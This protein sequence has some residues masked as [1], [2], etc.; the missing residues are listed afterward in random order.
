MYIDRLIL[1]FVAGA[2]LLS[3]VIIDWWSD[4]GSAWYRPYMVWGVL[5][6][7]AFWVTRSR[8]LNDL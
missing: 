5:I 7:L 8:D 4:G 3:P 6:A 2:Y 1:L